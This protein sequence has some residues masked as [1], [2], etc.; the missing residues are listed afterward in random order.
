MDSQITATALK[1]GLA[2]SKLRPA[3]PYLT[4]KVRKQLVNTKIKP[5]ALYGIQLYMGQPQAIIYKAASLVM[6]VNRYMTTNPE[7]SKSNSA[8]C[9]Y[10]KIDEPLQDLII[11]S[12]YFIHKVIQTKSPD[13]I[14][15]NL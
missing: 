11:S 1:V 6:R 4:P 5:I 3:L 7:G 12:F 15:K 14:I 9:K 10:L 2:I 13:K 8:L